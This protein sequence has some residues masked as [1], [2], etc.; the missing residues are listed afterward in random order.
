M[1]DHIGPRLLWML[2]QQKNVN[3][4]ALW[5]ANTHNIEEYLKVIQLDLFHGLTC[6]SNL[7]IYF[8]MIYLPMRQT[9]ISSPLGHE[10]V[11]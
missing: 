3:I 11:F 8:V 1:L 9:L 4:N 5:I 7:R 2:C 6:E 10:C